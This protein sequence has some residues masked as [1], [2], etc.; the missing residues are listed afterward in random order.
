M[1]SVFVQPLGHARI[2]LLGLS[3]AQLLCT[4]DAA[5]A[6]LLGEGR[7]LYEN[8]CGGCHSVDVDRVG[9]RHQDVVGRRV[10]SVAGYDYSPALKQ[11]GGVWTPARLDLWLSD[12]QKMAP[13]S[14][15]YLTLDDPHQRRLI[16]AY[17][18]SVSGRGSSP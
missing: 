5:A 9:P 15:M 3:L 18:Q 8:K 14:K 11:L 6:D 7:S 1:R 13:R 4:A 16:I 10:A 17:L 12:T 2:V